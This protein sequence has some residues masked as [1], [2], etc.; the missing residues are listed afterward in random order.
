LPIAVQ[1]Y[2]SSHCFSGLIISPSFLPRDEIQHL[3]NLD[4]L[5]GTWFDDRFM[6]AKTCSTADFIIY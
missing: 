5:I 6:N 3:K 2:L 1:K 4:L